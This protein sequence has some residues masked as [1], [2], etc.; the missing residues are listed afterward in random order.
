L[1]HY[2]NHGRAGCSR[3]HSIWALEAEVNSGGFS[4]YFFNSSRETAGFV[5]ETLRTVGALQTVV[6]CKQAIA[7]AFPAGLPA[8]LGLIRSAAADF[9][10]ETEAGLDALDNQFYQYP[11]NLTDLLYEYVS[12]HPEEFGHVMGEWRGSNVL[13]T[14]QSIEQWRNE[15]QR[16]IVLRVNSDSELTQTG[17]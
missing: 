8:D 16:K 14:D 15:G 4:Q 9:S 5:V 11:D 17:I 3:G 1:N 2:S 13:S 10:D 6:L 12:A 7:T